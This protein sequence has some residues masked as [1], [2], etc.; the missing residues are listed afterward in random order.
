ML[1]LYFLTIIFLLGLSSICYGQKLLFH[2]KRH[3]EA[4]YKEGDVISFNLRNDKSKITG[5]IR[6]FE[7]SLVV[8][9]G[10]KINPKEITHLYVDDKTKK[11]YIF[12]YK[13]E[14]I[15]LIAGVGYPLLELINNGEVDKEIL[16]IG[17]SLITTGLL[18]KWLIS[19][20]IKIKGRRRLLII[21]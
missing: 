4:L 11:W 9:S 5:Q 13:Y 16:I 21:D 15:F 8:F 12:R 3:R 6:G 19:N 14:K 1:K 7:D 20:K 17:G 18:A 2:K 10:F